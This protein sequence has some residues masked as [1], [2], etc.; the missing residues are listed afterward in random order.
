M[1]NIFL[2]FS[3]ILLVFISG[4]TSTMTRGLTLSLTP[5]PQTIFSG[6][7]MLLHIDMSNDD[8]KTLENVNVDVFDTGTLKG[9]RCVNAYT[10]ILPGQFETFACALYSDAIT[11]ERISAEINAK[12]SFKTT[13]SAV[14]ILQ[15]M[16]EREYQNSVSA[17]TF[18]QYPSSYTYRDKY[19]EMDVEFSESLPI[20]FRD[21][22][23][24]FV[25][26]TI[27]NVGNG[28]IEFIHNEDFFID[29]NGYLLSCSGKNEQRVYPT[30]YILE[31]FDKFPRLACEILI[32]NDIEYMANYDMTINLDYYYEIRDKTTVNIV[33]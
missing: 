24:Y 6:N 2:I 19:V 7:S 32:P 33:R 3:L 17:G 31:S 5:D 14:Q 15:L 23:R 22:Q 11:Q 20:V 12:V 21:G 29:Q 10:K 26:F 30:S 8:V 1:K 4:C 18:K 27:K 13:L 28:F 16:S 25:Y 9:D